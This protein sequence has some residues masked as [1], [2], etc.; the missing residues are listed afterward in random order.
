MWFFKKYKAIAYLPNSYAL[1]QYY[2]LEPNKIEDTFFLFDGA[3]PKSISSQ[4]QGAKILNL[5]NRYTRCLSSIM[6]HFCS[7][8]NRKTPVYLAS[9]ITFTNL[10]LKYVDTAFY[11]EDG[12]ASYELDAYKNDKQVI[13]RN[14]SMLNRWMYG[15]FYPRYGS[16]DTVLK[17]YL[18]GL[19]PIS[20]IIANKVELI[21]LKLLWQQKS[22]EQKENILKVFLPD[23]LNKSRLEKC[24]V[25]LLTQ[26]FSEDS[27][28]IFL[29]S[30]KIDV[31]RKLLS[32][33]DESKVLIKVHPRE[34][35]DYS[36]YFPKAQILRTPCPMEL[37]TLTG[38]QIKRAV[39]VNSTAIFS[40][41]DSVEKI[42][43][44]YDVTP[45]LIADT[46]RRGIY[47]GSSNRCSINQ[48]KS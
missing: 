28:D 35:T 9:K 29:E 33:Y 30:D 22:L 34:K 16:A 38:L 11:L 5:H 7:L 15:D 39:S 20:K 10:F 42:I 31:Y 21:N 46:K 13:E 48:K 18:T 19:L 45:A 36:H 43:S 23:G 24:E 14:T 40:L 12:T 27:D 26:P 47:D 4:V 8:L 41:D 17:I 44:G 2:L 6:V 32:G 37:L 3:F 1:L 25:L